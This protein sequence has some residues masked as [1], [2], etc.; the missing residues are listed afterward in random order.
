MDD[1]LK[2][3]SALQSKYNKTTVTA[4]DCVNSFSD[5][6]MGSDE[7]ACIVDLACKI[8]YS[9]WKEGK[10]DPMTKDE[11]VTLITAMQSRK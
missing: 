5:Y 1:E 6:E 8:T 11:L 10:Y 3:F 9:L 4:G 2:M 7:R